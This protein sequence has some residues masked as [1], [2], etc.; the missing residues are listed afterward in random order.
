MTQ[1]D[2]SNW[3]SVNGVLM[4]FGPCNILKS[5]LKSATLTLN[6]LTNFIPIKV[7]IPCKALPLFSTTILIASFSVRSCK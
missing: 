4:K 1:R 2:D 3:Y 7:S 5:F 6:I